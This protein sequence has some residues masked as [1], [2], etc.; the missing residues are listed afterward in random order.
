MY[1]MKV[2]SWQRSNYQCSDNN[3]MILLAEWWR[4]NEWGG[5]QEDSGCWRVHDE[6]IANTHSYA[7]LS[8]LRELTECSYRSILMATR[9]RMDAVEH[10]ISKA[11]QKS[12]SV[13]L[14]SQSTLT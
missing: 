11:I 9:L 2:Y 7:C 5:R 13:S 10:V 3:K 6:Q 14:K 8:C 4:S 1:T 12:Q